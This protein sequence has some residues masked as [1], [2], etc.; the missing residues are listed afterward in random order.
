MPTIARYIELGIKILE[1]KD[2]GESIEFCG[3]TRNYT[4]RG[5][6]KY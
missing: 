1:D 2:Y 6:A 5:F 3:W 4:I